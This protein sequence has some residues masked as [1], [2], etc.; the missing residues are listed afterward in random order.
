MGRGMEARRLGFDRERLA[1]DMAEAQWKQYMDQAMLPYDIQ[2]A[3][4]QPNLTQAR[5]DATNALQTQRLRPP[6]AEGGSN[7][8]PYIDEGFDKSDGR[9]HI[10]AFDKGSGKQLWDQTYE[11][12]PTTY[13]PTRGLFYGADGQLT[14]GEV[15]VGGG[16]PITQPIPGLFK[17]D[18]TKPSAIDDF[19]MRNLLEAGGDAAKSVPLYQNAANQYQNAL[20]NNSEYAPYYEEEMNKALGTMMGFA[21]QKGYFQSAQD[22]RKPATPHE[23]A[24]SGSNA[25][26]VS[27]AKAAIKA[28]GKEELARRLKTSGMAD[29]QINALMK[30]AGAQ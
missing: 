13:A 24:V 19:I 12:P 22:A 15:P 8:V 3:M 4:L 28:I 20:R 11:R 7:W 17:T 25:A 16:A 18:P 23:S 30:A 27:E 6:S 5:I 21:A 2:N 9:Y 10:R 1:Q 26:D 14:Y 29:D